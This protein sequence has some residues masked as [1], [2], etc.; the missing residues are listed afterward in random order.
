MNGSR[1]GLKTGILLLNALISGSRLCRGQSDPLCNFSTD[2]SNLSPISWSI[3]SFRTDWR[4][5]PPTPEEPIRFFDLIDFNA[6]LKNILFDER[7]VT[8]LGYF[9][10]SNE[11]G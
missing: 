4:Q 8:C 5:A 3:Q 1:M 6:T 7:L 9:P 11:Y 10:T 2:P